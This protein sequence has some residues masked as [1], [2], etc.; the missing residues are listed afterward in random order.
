MSKEVKLKT[1]VEFKVSHFFFQKSNIKLL[2]MWCG[3]TD[4]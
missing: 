3:V 1:I 4:P 2:K